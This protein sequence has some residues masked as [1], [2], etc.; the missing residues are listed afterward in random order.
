MTGTSGK[1]RKRREQAIWRGIVRLHRARRRDSEGEARTG[2]RHAILLAGGSGKRLAPMTREMTEIPLPKQFC[3]FTHDGA[4]LL[5]L[6]AHRAHHMVD[7][8]L[9]V[10]VR[11]AHN[12][13]AELVD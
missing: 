7:G 1:K 8:S 13:Y 9:R 3:S 5:Q 10:V 4:S 2:Q 6:T 12:Q 11:R